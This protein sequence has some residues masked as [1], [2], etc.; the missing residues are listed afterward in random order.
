MPVAKRHDNSLCMVIKWR[1]FSTFNGEAIVDRIDH[2]NTYAQATFRLPLRYVCY[3]RSPLMGH[4]IT[5]IS[6]LPRQYLIGCLT[7]E[8]W[9]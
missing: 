3:I 5:A 4:T 2:D 7:Q 9:I 1:H 8:P 6:L